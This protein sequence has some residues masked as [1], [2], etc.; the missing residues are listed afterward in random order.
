MDS[1]KF[2]EVFLTESREHLDT[3]NKCLLIL[4]K[5]SAD[6]EN[7][8]RLFRAFHTLKGNAATMGYL[9]FS[10]LAHRLEDV[11][12]GIRDGEIA[13]SEEVVDLVFKGADVLEEGLDRISQGKPDE[14]AGGLIEELGRLNSKSRHEKVSIGREAHLNENEKKKVDEAKKAGRNV[15]RVILVFDRA[16]PLKNGKAL[17]VM[18][19]LLE[20]C[21]IIRTVPSAD[22]IRQGGFESEIE[23]TVSTGLGRERVAAAVN[24]ISGIKETHVIGMDAVYEKSRDLETEENELAKARI[25]DEHR[26][27]YVRQIQGIKVK[28]S[29]LDKLMNL[30]GELLINNI[31]LQEIY[32]K[33]SYM[34][35]KPIAG[36]MDRLTI[37]LQD[38]VMQIRMVPIG[39]I[40]SR[41][42]RM[43]RD[44]TK[45]EGKKLSLEIS[46]QEIEFDRTV[47]DEIGEALLHLLRNCIDHGI[48]KP[49]QRL[50]HGKDET[51]TVRLAA[52]REKNSA[53][54]EVSDD[55]CGVDPPA[56]RASA[57][58]RGVITEE[59]A[60]QMS[61]TEL[62]MLIFRPGVSTNRIVTEVSGRGVGMDVVMSK[63]K[64]L[65][66]S[67]R[68]ESAVGKG[69]KVSMQLPLTL[70]IITTLLVKVGRH[71]YAIPLTSVDQTVE[72]TRESIK[73][74]Q[75]REVFIL[76]QKDIPLFWLSELLGYGRPEPAGKMTVAVVNKNEQQLGLVVDRILSQQQVL[77]KGLSSMLKGTRGVAGATILGDG[78][79]SM[80]LDIGTLV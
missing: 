9:S 70:A 78:S 25:A 55:G 71:R 18:R 19:K 37:D 75:G 45:K 30:V 7:I 3:I 1:E 34:E 10:E 36:A 38:E 16:N 52:R 20:S 32:K 68:F 22:S 21:S 5:D 46:G 24:S 57:V 51:G 28:M 80:I 77:I 72:I 42:P 66:G 74:L 56:V 15:Y 12:A 44:L 43:V 31:R 58:R 69:T 79:V 65:G 49:E 41:F 62:Q 13:V 47:L 29:K 73:T 48:E 11:L 63:I 59:E 53:V 8:S 35:L 54:I 61:D 17:L 26:E 50:E 4:E 27:K 2:R 6:A 14:P 76:R 39:D 67:I 40:F 33:N 23:I 60:M 64:E